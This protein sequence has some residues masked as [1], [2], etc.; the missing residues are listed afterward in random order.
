MKT[1]LQ[2]MN[3]YCTSEFIQGTSLT[4]PLSIVVPV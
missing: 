4:P 3:E 1:K 2:M